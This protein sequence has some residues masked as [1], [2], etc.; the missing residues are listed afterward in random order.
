MTPL[1]P[2]PEDIELATMDAARSPGSSA[3]ASSPA[4]VAF[5]G[6]GITKQK[7]NLHFR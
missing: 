6:D 3:N 5:P 4:R 7:T 1:P 2:K